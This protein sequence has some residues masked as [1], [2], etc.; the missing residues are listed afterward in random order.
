MKI[1][2]DANI[3][4]SG[5][6][7]TNGKIGDLLLN[8]HQTFQFISP[9]FLLGEILGK[10]EKIARISHLS[11]PSI[12]ERE[13]L[14]FK[15][16]QFISEAQIEKKYWETA[17]Q[18]VSDIDE[19]DT[20]YIAYSLRFQCKLWP[21]D[22]KLQKGLMDKGYSDIIHTQDLFNLREDLRK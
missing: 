21:G 6:L 16:I 19:K 5:I 22:K 18:L 12:L 15:N 9:N 20:P 11:I 7:N 13:F 3:I 10:H 17:Y 4:F 8:S 1:I 2:V 14:I